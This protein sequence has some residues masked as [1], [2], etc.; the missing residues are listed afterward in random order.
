MFVALLDTSVLW[1]SLQR[2]FLL[3]LHIQGA[4]RAIWSEAILDE[5][6]FHEA[7]KLVKRGESR[8]RAEERAAGL[9]R[10]MR[11]HFSDSIITGWEPLEGTFGLPDADDEHVAAAAFL[12]GAEVI[13]TLN[14]KDFPANRLP[15]SIEVL[16][17]AAF[18][19]N[20]VDL[21]PV[22]A[23]GALD[24]IVARSGRFGPALTRDSALEELEQRYA[25]HEAV[26]A[27]RRFLGTS[28]DA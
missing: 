2:D 18:A 19:R 24:E 16:S 14:L 4:Y 13:V 27:I 5:L 17:P 6:E 9:I 25:M 28:R 23:L 3:S 8:P 15:S 21:S 12:G 26:D 20:T 10:E 11:I 1:P 22:G 7:A